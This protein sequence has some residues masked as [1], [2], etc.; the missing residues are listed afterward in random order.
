MASLFFAGKMEDRHK[1]AIFFILAGPLLPYSLPNQT[2]T[3]HTDTIRAL[4][5]LP[6]CHAVGFRYAF[7]RY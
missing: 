6:N 4:R 2:I 7:R 5:T 3:E 1:I